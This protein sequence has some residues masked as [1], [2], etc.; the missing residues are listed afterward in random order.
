[1]KTWLVLVLSAIAW[2]KLLQTVLNIFCLDDYSSLLQSTLHRAGKRSQSRSSR[3][4]F[5]NLLARMVFTQDPAE[6]VPSVQVI[7]MCFG[8]FVFG[9][10]T[11]VQ[12][13]GKRE[14]ESLADG[15]AHLRR[16][17]WI[18]CCQTLRHRLTTDLG[19]HCLVVMFA[20]LAESLEMS[21]HMRHNSAV[22]GSYL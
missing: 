3:K 11:T 9:R 10:S 19:G 15:S 1:M 6:A 2:P 18:L 17:W 21:A 20:K 14:E 16:G 8:G 13:Q 5:C 7:R 22:S 12:Q 4:S